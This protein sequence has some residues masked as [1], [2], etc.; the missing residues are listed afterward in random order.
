MR[1]PINR[2]A[3]KVGLPPGTLLHVGERKTEKARITVFD[4][5]ERQFQEK[6]IDRVE[7]CFPFR[8]T[9]TVTWINVDG[10]HD[11]DLVDRLG[12]HFGI[13]PLVLE[14]IVNPHQRP[15]TEDFEQYIFIVGKMLSHDSRQDSVDEEQVGIVL[16]PNF[17]IS[18]QERQGDLFEPVR[19]RLRHGKGRVRKMGAD[20]LSYVLLDAIVDGYFGI[21][22]QI[23]ERTETLEQ[24]LLESP[25]QKTLETIHGLRANAA[26]LRRSIWPMRDAVSS[27]ERGE[28]TL[29]H[30]STGI[31]FRDVHDHAVRVV[32]TIESLRDTL[33]GMADLYLSSLSNKMNETM[34]VL[35][36]I[37]TIFIPLTFI[38]GIYGMNFENMPELKWRWGYA[39]VLLAMAC[40]V[41]LMIA[42]F[43]RKKW[44]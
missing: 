36:T 40:V 22:E 41:A 8:D 20:Y 44:L 34:K 11:V 5:D 19:D 15:K 30:E 7:D 27:L 13:H 31:Y 2:P 39:M 43:R 24:E 12:Q 29:I 26:L 33:S 17:V 21:L 38:A 18:F 10:L 42:Y 37:A 9:A 28:S 6:Q 16:G 1:G 35:T 32:E 14:D 25:T 3:D 23:S 4:Y